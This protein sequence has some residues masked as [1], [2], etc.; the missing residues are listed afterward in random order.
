MASPEESHQYNHDD[1]EEL[2]AGVEVKAEAENS[3]VEDDEWL[4][5]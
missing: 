2:W 5:L 3:N 4:V 1:V